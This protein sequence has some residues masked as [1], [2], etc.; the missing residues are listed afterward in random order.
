MT[1]DRVFGKLRVSKRMATNSEPPM[2]RAR[3]RKSV[4]AGSIVVG[5]DSIVGTTGGGGFLSFLCY[6]HPGWSAPA[7]TPS[8]AAGGALGASDVFFL[9]AFQ[10]A[11]PQFAELTIQEMIASEKRYY[12]RTALLHMALGSPQ[13]LVFTEQFQSC[14]KRIQRFH[15]SPGARHKRLLN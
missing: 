4:S 6:S 10:C 9:R 12:G 14:I 2:R 8:L 3:Y 5:T 13:S 15:A 11:V 7:P 1:S